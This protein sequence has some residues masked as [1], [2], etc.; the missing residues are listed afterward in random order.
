MAVRGANVYAGLNR[1]WESSNLV[2]IVMLARAKDKK[3]PSDGCTL[4]RCTTDGKLQ[5]WGARVATFE[6]LPPRRLEDLI[7]VLPAVFVRRLEI[8]QLLVK[9][10]DIRFELCRLGCEPRLD[11]VDGRKDEP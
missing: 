6:L 9:T 1:Y 4:S 8:V 11:T 5:P 10:R 3:Q 2:R 7:N